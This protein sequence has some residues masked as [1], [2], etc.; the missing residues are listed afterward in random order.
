MYSLGKLAR[1]AAWYETEERVPS[2]KK[3]KKKRC[4]KGKCSKTK[5]NRVQNN[6]LGGGL[7]GYGEVISFMFGGGK[8]Q[9][10][11]EWLP[12]KQIHSIDLESRKTSH[13]HCCA[14]RIGNGNTEG[15]GRG[16]GCQCARRAS[17]ERGKTK[18]V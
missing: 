17:G 11:R 8:G 14:G 1:G 18:L 12:S 2:E 10:G 4:A 5:V 16:Q 15:G 6:Q 13:T 9:K 7:L 3:S